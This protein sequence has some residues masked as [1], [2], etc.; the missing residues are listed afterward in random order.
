[1]VEV[2]LKFSIPA[3]DDFRRRLSKFVVGPSVVSQ[4]RDV[5]FNHSLQDFA[6]IDLALR[7]RESDDEFCVTFKGPNRDK[8]AKI[9]SE[10]ELSLEDSTAAKK[11]KAIF[12]GC[13]FFEEADVVKRR[14]SFEIELE[15]QP[16][17]ICIDEVDELGSFVELEMLVDDSSPGQ[18]S[19][20]APAKAQLL[21]FANELGLAN[22][23]T[24]SYLD[25]LLQKRGQRACE[26]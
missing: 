5:Y 12:L 10:T 20:V 17:Q 2:E 18:A 25:L 22:P 14:E 15:G 23:I 21:K 3:P 26:F 19:L 1:M 8:Q 24:T 16:V 4:Q 7:I 6:K 11:M 9:R 13:G